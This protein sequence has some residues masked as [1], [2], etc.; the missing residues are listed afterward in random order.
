MQKQCKDLRGINHLPISAKLFWN[1]ILGR[2]QATFDL[3]LRKEK[4]RLWPKRSCADFIFTLD[5]MLEESNEW[6]QRLYELFI[7]FKKAFDQ[8]NL[9]TVLRFYGIP[10]KLVPLIFA[11]YKKKECGVKT[12]NG[13]MRYFKVMTAVKQGCV[14]LSFLFVLVVDYIFRQI[15]GHGIGISET[16]TDLGIHSIPTEAETQTV[17]RQCLICSE[18]LYR[19]F[20]ANFEIGETSYRL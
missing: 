14:L 12:S 11:M 1:I 4:H 15:N 10:E 5:T 18:L 20:K 7:D 2:L 16:S 19:M 6:G 17:P 9:S 13:N 8:R 3:N